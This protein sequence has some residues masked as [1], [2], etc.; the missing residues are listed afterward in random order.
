MVLNLHILH[1]LSLLLLW[2]GIGKLYS[3]VKKAEFPLIVLPLRRQHGMLHPSIK[4]HSHPQHSPHLLPVMC[5]GSFHP[6]DSF[7]AHLRAKLSIF[8]CRTNA[9]TWRSGANKNHWSCCPAP[10]PLFLLQIFFFFF[11]PIKLI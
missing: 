3:G 2:D 1:I 9:L 6:A 11:S 4:L 8:A 10:S 5:R 7:V